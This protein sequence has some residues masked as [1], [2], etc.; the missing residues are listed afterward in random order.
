[1]AVYRYDGPKDGTSVRT[2]PFR[3]KLPLTAGGFA[4]S[5]IAAVGD[6][7]TITDAK[8]CLFVEAV[9]DMSGSKLFTK[10]S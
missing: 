4:V 2:G 9:K 3:F 1:M 5:E 10:T 8:S 6:S 7:I